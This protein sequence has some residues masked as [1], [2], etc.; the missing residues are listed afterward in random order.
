MVGN[1]IVLYMKHAFDQ[2][3]RGGWKKRTGENW[4]LSLRYS[5]EVW[6]QSANDPESERWKRRNEVFDADTRL[7]V[8]RVDV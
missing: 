7:Y 4:F 3:A 8:C 2:E 6:P 5:F 1:F